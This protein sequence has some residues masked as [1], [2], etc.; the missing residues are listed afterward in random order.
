LRARPHESK[1]ETALLYKMARHIAL[2]VA[3]NLGERGA[4]SP[5]CA[6]RC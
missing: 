5:V 4:N 2:S 1:R 3:S 6:W